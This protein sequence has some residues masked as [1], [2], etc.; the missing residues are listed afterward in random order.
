VGLGLP[1]A[2]LP[3]LAAVP[4]LVHGFERK[5]GG[6][7]R[8]TRESWRRRTAAALSA[9]GRQ[10]FQRQVHGARV[11]TAPWEGT[12]EG[13]G[14][15]ATAPRLLLAIETADC[16]PVLIVDPDG[17]RV[18][19][20][21]AGWRGTAASVVRATATALIETGSDPARLLAALGPA[22]GACCYEVGEE[23]RSAFGPSGDRFFRAGPGGKLFL[24][25]RAAN[26]AQ[27]LE[28][29]LSEPHILG[30]DECTACHPERYHSYR[31][32]GGGA[33][34][35]ISYIGFAE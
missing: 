33:G 5:T 13:D 6:G 32:D 27:L 28:T 2:I 25:L 11:W 26:R 17:R 29:G 10:L 21:H 20:A 35:M 9:S 24:D 30:I 18:G 8:E 19:A 14:A 16:L 34:R 12:P 4:G 1:S 22:I 23:L 7:V 3:T 31:R 15:I